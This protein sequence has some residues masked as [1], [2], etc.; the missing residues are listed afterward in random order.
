MSIGSDYKK[1]ERNNEFLQKL[2]RDNTENIASDY[3]KLEGDSGEGTTSDYR[4]TE[5]R[6]HIKENTKKIASDHRKQKKDNM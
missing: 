6:Q 1:L 4:I 3:R 2:E 5:E